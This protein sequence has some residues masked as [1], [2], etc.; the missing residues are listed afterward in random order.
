MTMTLEKPGWHRLRVRAVHRLHH[1]GGGGRTRIQGAALADPGDP[2]T[3]RRMSSVMTRRLCCWSGGQRAGRLL[4]VHCTRRRSR[5]GHGI[6]AGRCRFSV[7]ASDLTTVLGLAFSKDGALYVLETPVKNADPAPA[8]GEVVRV[9]GS[10]PCMAAG[11]KCG[12]RMIAWPSASVLR[13]PWWF[14]RSA[15]DA[16]TCLA[17]L[18][19]QCSRLE[20]RR[21]RYPDQVGRKDRLRRH[22]QDC[23]GSRLG[24]RAYRMLMRPGPGQARN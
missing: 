15:A 9:K 8:A 6:R 18:A 12:C 19:G 24:L 3:T 21:L 11:G 5:R 10:Q 7:F 14:A 20:S 13:R 2:L 22:D 16:D 1:P 23:Q 4:Q 17:L